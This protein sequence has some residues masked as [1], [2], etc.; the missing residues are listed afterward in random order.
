MQQK[1]LAKKKKRPQTST[2]S[3]NNYLNWTSINYQLLATVVLLSVFGIIMIYSASYYTC[4]TSAAYNYDP[5][6]LLKNQSTFVVLGLIVM[7]L[8]SFIN[9]KVWEKFWIVAGIGAIVVIVLLKVPGLGVTVKGATRWIKIGAIQFQAAEPAKLALIIFLSAFMWKYPINLS[10]N[11]WIALFYVLG[12]SGL[13]L[14]LSENMSTA[15]IMGG[16]GVGMIFIAHKDIKVFSRIA[17]GVIIIAIV[18]VLLFY[19]QG[20]DLDSTSGG[21]RGS[22]IKAWLFPEEYAANQGMQALQSLYAIS[23]GGFF[24]KGL[25]N[26]LQKFRLPEAHNDFIL[27]II[28]EELGIFGVIL[29]L[30]LF[31]YLLYLIATIALEATDLF[32]KL[33][34]SGVFLQI[35]IQVILNVAVVSNA[36][37]TTGVTLPFISSGGASVVFLMAELGVVF[38]IDKVTKEYHIRQKVIRDMRMKEN[39]ERNHNETT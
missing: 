19:I 31:A 22:R 23:L 36:M 26:S 32:G 4:A 20:P 24:G 16:M 28:A 37:P 38:S 27:S 29:L 10:R 17:L 21:F 13:V 15:M 30:L 12:L 9:Y 3:I 33:I 6:N 34:A 7:I 39:Y 18:F 2:K 8:L 25:G 1:A 11:F 14:L 35:G 5:M